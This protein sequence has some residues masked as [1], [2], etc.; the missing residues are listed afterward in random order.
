MQS[1]A[2]NHEMTEN[3]ISH[4]PQKIGMKLDAVIIGKIKINSICLVFF[5]FFVF[6]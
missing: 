5:L 6:C 1:D 4:I 2:V 3:S